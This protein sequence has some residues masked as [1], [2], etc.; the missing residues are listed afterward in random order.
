MSKHEF[1]LPKRIK[2]T[3]LCKWCGVAKYCAALDI[4]KKSF[5]LQKIKDE[6]MLD[7]EFNQ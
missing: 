5:D 1:N 7:N 3:M 6:K 2:N 4:S